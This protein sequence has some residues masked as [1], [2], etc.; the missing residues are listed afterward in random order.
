MKYYLSISLRVVSQ[1][2]SVQVVWFAARKECLGKREKF[3]EIFP[4]CYKEAKNL[5]TTVLEE[6]GETME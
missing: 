2:S 6:G 3:K 1:F 4:R 5:L